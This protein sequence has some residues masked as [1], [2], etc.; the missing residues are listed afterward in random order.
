MNNKRRSEILFQVLDKVYEDN[1]SM[2]DKEIHDRYLQRGKCV[3]SQGIFCFAFVLFVVMFFIIY[4]F[5]CF[6]IT[7]QKFKTMFFIIA[8]QHKKQYNKEE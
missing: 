6:I 4:D 5:L 1:P 2:R 7:N 8:T 3:P